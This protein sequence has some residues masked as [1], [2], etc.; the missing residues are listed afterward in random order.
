MVKLPQYKRAIYA[1]ET[2]TLQNKYIR[3][4]VHRRNSG[5]G[6]GEVYS[7]SGKLMCVFEHLGEIMIRDQDIPMRLEAYEM[8][9]ESVESGERLSFQVKSVVVQESSMELRLRTG[10]A[11]H[12][13]SIFWMAKS[14]L[15][16]H[17]TSR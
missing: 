5:W 13:M 6:W 8:R 17:Q 9:H 14:H 10:C 2:A 3:L 16:L 4:D 15:R 12:S 7:P 11:I 1:N